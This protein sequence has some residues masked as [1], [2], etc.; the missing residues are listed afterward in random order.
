M[1]IQTEFAKAGAVFKILFIEP[2]FKMNMHIEAFIKTAKRTVKTIA[3][4]LH[5]H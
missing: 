4:I 5:V 1:A 3:I 2:F